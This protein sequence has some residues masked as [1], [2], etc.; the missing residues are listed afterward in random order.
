MKTSLLTATILA[1]ACTGLFAPTDAH[2]YAC[3]VR[4]PGAG[5]TVRLRFDMTSFWLQSMELTVRQ[6]DEFAEA[7]P[8]SICGVARVLVPPALL[9][10]GALAD[11]QILAMSAVALKP[12]ARLRI[13]EHPGTVPGSV[14]HCS[15]TTSDP[16]ATCQMNG[17]LYRTATVLNR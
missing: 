9:W 2:A 10:P 1:L 14:P 3:L 7:N 11:G 15:T 17:Y 16:D 13:S 6:F 4:N 12:G 5:E 8:D